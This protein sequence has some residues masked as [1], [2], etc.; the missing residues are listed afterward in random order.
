MFKKYLSIYIYNLFVFLYIYY[1][2]VF[3]GFLKSI[4]CR[5]KGREEDLKKLIREIESQKTCKKNIFLIQ[6]YL[7]FWGE[8]GGGKLFFMARYIY[9]WSSIFDYHMFFKSLYYFKRK[10][11]YIFNLSR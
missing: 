5:Y 3:S 10:E 2:Y 11:K 9:S 4:K 1:I 8:E 6:K 7:H